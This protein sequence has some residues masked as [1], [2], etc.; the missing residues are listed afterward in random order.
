[1]CGIA[2]V[3]FPDRINEE[4]VRQISKQLQS[5]GPDAEG[6]SRIDNIALIHRRLKIIDLSDAANQPFT[7]D[8]KTVH[9][10]FNGEIYN[11]LEL[12][13]ELQK[14]GHQ[15][16]TNSDTE[17]VLHSYLEWGENCFGKFNGMFAMGIF[18]QRGSPKLY[19]A[20]DRFGVKPL[21]YFQN[22]QGFAFASTFTALL[23][24]DFLPRTVDNDSILSF[25]KFG[26]IPWSS[27]YFQA[28]KQLE[29]GSI[30]LL[31]DGNISLKAF[32]EH[33]ITEEK[34]FASF[35]EAQEA[36]WDAFKKSVKRQSIAD[37]PLG[38]FLSGGIDSSLIVAA[39]RAEQ[40][41][42]LQTFSIGFSEKAYDE[43][44][45]ARDVAAHFQTEHREFEFSARH[46]IDN[47]DSSFA[48][49]DAPLADPAF[50]P[51]LLLAKE[52]KKTVTVAFSGDGGDEF[53]FGYPHQKLL[54]TFYP[55][56]KLPSSLRNP[57]LNAVDHILAAFSPP[58]VI[59]LQ[60]ARKLLQILQFQNEQ[61]YLENF[62]GIFGPLKRSL[63]NQLLPGAAVHSRVEE[64]VK[65][66]LANEKKIE[67]AFQ[68]TFLIDTALAKT[69]RAS[70]AYGLESRVP[71]L[72]NEFVKL[73]ER[74]PIE[75]KSQHGGKWILR[76]ILKSVLPKHLHA[77][78]ANRQKQ[79]FQL[80]IRYWLKREL[81]V[82]L[83]ELQKDSGCLNPDLV[84]LVTHEHRKG[85][86][87]HSHLLWAMICLRRWQKQ[88]QI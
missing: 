16:R 64:I 36:I 32:R 17:V 8:A 15:F 86:Q 83:E 49:M 1:M 84:K 80:P 34:P 59:R 76:S 53:F 3:V 88:Y 9:L 46:C 40:E 38:C 48:F 28:I 12:K 5:R 27:S 66:P 75:W 73:V 21:Y 47:F 22:G 13:G 52:T 44:K 74:I 72:D 14:L 30:L 58:K 50:I 55:C 25:L 78:I 51:T 82:Y 42:K 56:T 29:P 11:F 87:N 20:R 61:E 71:F 26:H 6:I 60:Q 24:L 2:G 70:M 41:G 68:S 57:F 43:R 69:D 4:A 35:A 31:Q 65:M 19:L 81:A 54:Q 33:P 79:G 37:V 10:V 18:D 7:N 63:L 23:P 67:L 62:I 39:Q 77:P 85:I 45:Y